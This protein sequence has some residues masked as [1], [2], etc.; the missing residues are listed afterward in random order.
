MGEGLIWKG[1]YGWGA[2]HTMRSAY[3]ACGWCPQRIPPYTIHTA[4]HAC[5]SH[6]L[7]R[8]RCG[9]R[10]ARARAAGR[11]DAAGPCRGAPWSY[12]RN[13]PHRSY[14][15]LCAAA[16]CRTRRCARRR[17]WRSADR[18][19]GT[20][21]G[22]ATGARHGGLPNFSGWDELMR[23]GQTAR[24]GSQ[25]GR[26]RASP[27]PAGSGVC[28]CMAASRVVGVVPRGGGKR[29]AGR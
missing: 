7:P 21:R 22:P 5:A 2:P 29:M 9:G 3:H 28:E 16:I 20:P 17:G 26:I 27:R 6:P 15:R 14:P 11:Y 4:H 10:R 13:M 8:W 25:S 18:V 24:L 12:P 1:R 23:G 19:A